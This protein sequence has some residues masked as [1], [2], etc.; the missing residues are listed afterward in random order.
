MPIKGVSVAVAVTDRNRAAE[1]YVET[2]G[3]RRIE[4]DGEHWLTV[5]DRSGKFQL[6]LCE[7]GGRSG[8]K[9][10]KSEVG[11]TG[12]LLVATGPFPNEVRRLRKAGV[13]FSVPPVRRP[14]GWVSKFLDP[15]GNEFWFV[16]AE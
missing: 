6:H 10:P 9:P 13:R 1:W 16:P 12:I 3:F 4:D 2:L 5:G 14:W 11:N 7:V 8:K 15:D